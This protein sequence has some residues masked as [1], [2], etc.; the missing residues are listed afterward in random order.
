M[1][2][3]PQ[4]TAFAGR[5]GQFVDSTDGATP[6]TG[7]SIAATDVQ[8]S[9][10]GT[11]NFAN[12][13]DSN[14]PGHDDDGWYTLQLDATD[15]A[16]AGFLRAKC[17]VAGA[18]GVHEDF[19]VMPA[20][21]WAMLY[22][23]SWVASLAAQTAQAGAAGT[24]TLAAA[25]SATD[26]LYNGQ[27][28]YI[29]SGTGAGQSRTIT[30]YV[31]STKV[32]TVDT[33]WATNPDNTS[34]Y[35]TIPSSGTLLSIV[36][37]KTDLIAAT[38]VSYTSP[39]ASDGQSLNLTQGEAYLDSLSNAVEMEITHPAFS[40]A[41]TSDGTTVTLKLKRRNNTA[42]SVSVTG[43]VASVASTTATVKFDVT[44]AVTAA[45]AAGFN[46][47]RH[48]VVFEMAGVSTDVVKPV[49]DAQTTV[50]ADI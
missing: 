43:S 34:V 8:V 30:D 41:M 20:A 31:G 14:A 17:V 33:A 7:L 26:D 4:S 10:N 3:I 6:E 44:A 37:A 18:L 29:S 32:A 42:A 38:G 25:A 46:A 28:I 27:I 35:T 21:P 40:A 36:R 48:D 13:N 22:G 49:V 16:S 50:T 19:M 39:V 47:Y 45:L 11:P 2:I 1:F 5:M 24:I 15:T 23:D 9:K 12:K